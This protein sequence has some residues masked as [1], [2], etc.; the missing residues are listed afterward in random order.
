MSVK[1]E[2]L[3]SRNI[4][5]LS[6]KEQ[7]KI[8][9]TRVAVLG[10]GGGSEIARQLTA[11]GFEKLILADYDRV[12]LHNLN[13]QFYFQKDIGKNK[14]RALAENLKAINPHL[15]DEIIT[16]RITVDSVV[17]IAERADIIVDALPPETALKEEIVL[18]RKVRE[19]SGK[20]H[21][22]F[23]DIVWGAKAVVFSRDSQTFEEFMG[24][25]P[26]C[27]LSAVDQLSLEDLTQN[28]LVDASKD[29]ARVGEMLYKNEL[30][31]FPQMAIT[32]SLAGSMVTTLCIFLSLGKK[33]HL[34]PKV[35]HIDYYRDF[36]NNDGGRG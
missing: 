6:L 27:D 14:A 13:R 28:Y 7:R 15:K 35:F 2:D 10:C 30:D 21:L 4:G 17:G 22:Y 36:I 25:K 16:K 24:L 19:S 31:Y 12:E 11:S 26:N 33:V 29:M 8:R 34:A 20:Y 9:N 5:I 18:S 23:L 3:F 32:V 1:Y